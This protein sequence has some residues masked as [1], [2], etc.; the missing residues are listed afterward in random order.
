[1]ADQSIRTCDRCTY[2]IDQGGGVKR[3]CKRR[4]CVYGPM[5]WQHT[6]IVEGVAI[7][8]SNIRGTGKGLFATKEIHR[9]CHISRYG[10]D[11]LN[12]GQ[13]NRRYPPH[14]IAQYGHRISAN[15]TIDARET[16]SGNARYIN[17]PGNEHLYK[18]QLKHSTNAK[19]RVKAIEDIEPGEEIFLGY[20]DEF[21]DGRGPNQRTLDHAPPLNR[22][23]V[24][25]AP[26]RNVRGRGRG[27]RGG[28]GRGGN[29]RNNRQ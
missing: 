26:R 19:R 6:Q 24:P 11:T 22:R 17:V 14:T 20:G 7:D 25:R 13:F 12:A 27:V 15:R 2:G 23:Y 29:R 3:R 4:T 18:A 21:W 16:N 8:I 1:M 10:G 5:C 28:R 9:G